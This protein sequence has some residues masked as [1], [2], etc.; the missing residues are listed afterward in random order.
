MTP[1]QHI[2]TTVFLW[3]PAIFI[4]IYSS[5]WLGVLA[6]PL[7]FI[8]SLGLSVLITPKISMDLMAVWAWIKPPVIA[9]SVISMALLLN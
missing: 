9:G 7:S 3:G 2:W 8:L 5:W 4:G 1:A 6:V